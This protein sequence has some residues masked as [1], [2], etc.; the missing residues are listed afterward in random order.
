MH[1]KTLMLLLAGMVTMSRAPLELKLRSTT[2]HGDKKMRRQKLVIYISVVLLLMGS[3][4]GGSAPRAENL[5]ITLQAEEYDIIHVDEAQQKVE[6]EG[7]TNLLEPGKPMLPARCF[8]IALPPGA[9]VLSV[10]FIES[11]LIEVQGRYQII[12]ASPF[13]PQDNDEDMVKECLD[14]W[15]RNYDITYSSD[16]AFP[17][18]AGE[19]LGTGG[20]RKYTFI[21]VAY[22]PFSYQPRSGRLILRPSLTVSIDYNLPML[23]DQEYERML[24]DTKGD[25]LASRLF[26]N[27]AE[28]RELYLPLGTPEPPKQNYEYVIITTDALITAV[29]SLVTWKETLGYSVNV[30]TTSWIEGSYSGSDLEEKIR[31]FLIDKYID[32]GIEYVLIAGDVDVIPMRHCFPDPSNHNPNS[33]YSPPSDYYYADLTGDWDSDGDGYHGEYNEDNV[34]FIPEV[35]VGRIPHSDA[36]TVTSICQKLVTFEGDNSSWKDN[37]LLLGAMSNYYNEDYSSGPRTDGALLM[38]NMISDM[39]AGWSYTTMYEEAGLNPNTLG[40]DLSLNHTNVMNN[41]SANDY[42]IVNWWAH[43]SYDGAWRKWWSWDDGDGVPETQDPDEMGWEVFLGN[44]DVSSLDDGHPSLI[45]SCSCNNSWPE[46]DNLARRLLAAGSA[47]IV[48]STRVSWYTI[49]WLDE[50]EGGNASIDYYYF[51]YM[52]KE[53][54]SLGNALFDSKIYY[55]NH[56]FWWGWESQQNMFDFCLYGDPSM[57]RKLDGL[58]LH[59]ELIDDDQVG[60]SNG[61]SD[62]E[63]D[64]GETIEMNIVLENM[65]SQSFTQISA[66]LSSEDPLVTLV[67]DN[68]GFPDASSWT[69][70]TSL[71]PFVFSVSVT[72]PSN[73]VVVFGLDITTSGGFFRHQ[74]IELK[75]EA[76]EIVI[77]SYTINDMAF[78]DGDGNADPGETVNLYVEL[79]NQ[80]TDGLDSLWAK[81]STTDPYV[82]ILVDSTNYGTSLPGNT[83]FC[84]PPFEFSVDPSCTEDPY[85]ILF[86]LE[87]EGERGYERSS[88][89]NTSV[90]DIIGY[91]DD[92][93]MGA[94]GWFHYP[95]TQGYNDEWHLSTE[96]NYTSGG[97]YSWK[98]GQVSA[99]YSDLD[100]AG[101]VSPEVR[102]GKDGMLS[103]WH[104]ISAEV[105]DASQAWDGGIL[106]IDDGSGWEQITPIGG[107]PYTIIDNPASPFEGGTPCFSGS[108]DWTQVEFD[109]SE[110]SGTVRFRFRFGTDG[111]TTEAGWF[112]DDFEVTG[113]PFPPYIVSTSPAQNELSVPVSTNISVIFDMDM[114]A[115][116]I[117][118]STFLVNARS[119]GLH[120]G[121]I[122]YDGPT[123]TATFDPVQDFDEGEVVTVALTTGVQSYDGTPL[124][125][126]YVWSFTSAVD[127]GSGTFAPQS[128]YA[129]GDWPYT[130]FSAD[131]DGDGDLDLATANYYSNNASVLLN[132]GDGTF[133]PQSVY[134]VG[135]RPYSVFSADLDGDGDLDLATA[136]Y[137]TDNVSV[138]LNN[139]DGTFAPHSVYP[140]GDGPLSVFSADL[141]GDG[142]LDLATANVMSNNVSVLLNNGDGTFATQSVYPVGVYPYSVFSADLDGDGDLDLVTANYYS[143]NVSVLLN[144]GNGTFAAHSVYAV[145]YNPASVFSADL[146]GD[147]DLDLAVANESFNNVSVLLN[148]PGFIRGDANG[149]AT[150]NLSDAIYL[151]N[152]LFRSGFPP[153]PLEAG[154][155]NCDE[156]VNLSDAIYLLNYL[157][158]GGDPPGCFETAKFLLRGKN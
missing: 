100:D 130:V 155:A 84:S 76:P 62:G 22:F 139:G 45:F 133:A 92:M 132:Y 121:T 17:E 18:N 158:K 104:W 69:R 65:S 19:Y 143:N 7:F 20:L 112:I 47:G 72:S 110:Y 56:S 27:Y 154:D 131:L 29:S 42:G 119:T 3:V 106:E 82:N 126:A 11:N 157:F 75:V 99:N 26:V 70:V 94:K 79:F 115:S 49:G 37:A 114:D 144:N 81:L 116:S 43:G 125:G 101:L 136:N 55:L 83:V 36:T 12:P 86:E 15:Q 74:T 38:E 63:V 96:R 50:S 23:R 71:E 28:I 54:E 150:I 127:D 53:S 34:D 124:E 16:K 78:G 57:R 13:L 5:T 128:V 147:G 95:V 123:K 109:L 152:Y 103:F 120:S 67:D 138:L 156:V 108:H 85:I 10:G 58:F 98:C 80:G 68:I 93:E 40:C 14:L 32:W 111:N 129:V 30:V 107:Y 48:A 102:L 88:S 64:A 52:I 149:D 148:E 91:F 90:G 73:H 39:L 25:R 35:Y 117:N 59:S 118:G 135:D 1:K 146:D 51:Y 105:E 66:S 8:M 31:A 77:H 44:S 153:D 97:S 41:W 89:F 9:E 87:M 4:V 61:D 134:A 151:L 137:G 33:S 122:T 46:L 21:R 6:M 140:V 24:V 60:Q 145:G 141:D 2:I 113:L 142:D